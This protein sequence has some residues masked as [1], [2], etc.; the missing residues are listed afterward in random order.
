MALTRLMEIKL[1]LPR[2][3]I[4][5]AWI[6]SGLCI[7]NPI[8]AQQNQDEAAIEVIQ[9]FGSADQLE[10]A[11]GSAN[12][13]NTE[14][15][16]QFEYDDIH[17]V[18]QSVPGVYIRQEDG[19]G[20]RPNIG[21]RGATTERS[22]KIALMEDGILIAPA[23]YAAPAAYYFPLISRMQK[24]EVFKG[25]AAIRFGPNTVGGAINMVSTAIEEPGHGM[26]DFAVG[27]QGYRKAYGRFSESVGQFDA[28]VEG[29]HLGADGFK[30]LPSGSDTGFEK[31]EFMTK[32]AYSPSD[33]NY[34]QR[35]LFKLAYADEVSEE[36]YLGITDIDFANDPNQRYA[37]SELDKL[38]WEHLQMSLSHYIELTADTVISTQ[39]Y[40][41]DFN[42]DWD[43]LNR[44]V[45]TR[46]I[47]TILA[48]PETGLNSL[49]VGVL[50]G[51]RDSLT[52]DE[53]LIQ[54]LN[55]RTYYSQGLQTKVVQEYT[56]N[57]IDLTLDIGL[58]I[59]QDEVERLHRDRFFLMRSG[60]LERS[61]TQLD[62]VTTDNKDKVT[63][64]A[65]YV[66]SQWQWQDLTVSAGV[67][68]ENIDADARDDFNQS[69]ISSSDTVV[70]PG[71]GLFYQLNKNIGVLAGV[72]KGFVPNSPGQDS[73]IDAEESWNYELGVRTSYQSW[74]ASAIGFFNDYSNLKGTCTFSSGCLDELNQEFNGGAVDVYGAEVNITNTF[75]LGALSVP[76]NIAYTHTQTEFQTAFDS[77]FA[78]WGRV[79]IG[80]E[81]PYIPDNQ[82]SVIAGLAANNWR[83]DVSFKYVDEMREAAGTNTSLSGLFTEELNQ[84]D[85]S[86][87]Y[88]WSEQVRLYAK[89]DNLTDE[90]SIVSRRPFGARP[91][92]PRQATIGVK[93]N[94]Q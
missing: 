14:T 71:V 77:S 44:F 48:S 10:R 75:V 64:I 90:Q 6:G 51:E 31:N 85:I 81:L 47:S 49:F 13:I 55:D 22:S 17:R 3:T 36:T 46:P 2:L 29:L 93:Y 35:W 68:V 7:A 83:V 66:D 53:T 69:S 91:N 15:L 28:L 80:D 41:R 88:Q 57:Q 94:F 72:N 19:Y 11:T 27:E 76:L 61:I 25:P 67:R 37:A 82:V 79:T 73:D 20:L 84:W 45:S 18:L 63:A 70:L 33:S 26:L 9:I 54:T 1:R 5:A 60:Q 34:Y 30:Q 21:L 42:R 86:G 23:P 52:D 40:R 58:R 78:Q 16:E 24:V 4:L 56:F 89:I 92:K 32:L 50:K 59:H 62:A 87:W 65:S 38:D 74:Q 43:R 8:L 12:I 39:L